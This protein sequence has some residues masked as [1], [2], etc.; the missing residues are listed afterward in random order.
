MALLLPE[1]E[2]LR[3]IFGLGVE[4]RLMEVDGTEELPRLE[5]PDR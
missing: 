1:L 4:L 2:E 3:E 5:G